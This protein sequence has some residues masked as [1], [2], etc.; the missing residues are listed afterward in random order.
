M[1]VFE[2][3]KFLR[4]GS[5]PLIVLSAETKSSPTEIRRSRILKR[6]NEFP[7]IARRRLAARR[8]FRLESK[9]REPSQ[10]IKVCDAR[11]ASKFRIVTKKKALGSP[12]QRRFEVGRKG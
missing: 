8:L 9:S 7:G 12:R 2:T 11:R 6:S 1:F 10:R 4:S 3:V 5:T